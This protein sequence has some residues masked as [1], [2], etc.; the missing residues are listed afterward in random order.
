MNINLVAFGIA[1]DILGNSTQKF[2]LKKGNT[3]EE[4]KAELTSEF[5]K[6]EELAS[7]K[8]AVNETYQK[9]DFLLSE[10]DEVV[11]IP[12]VSGG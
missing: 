6:F 9:D 1:R 7:L 4:L 5:P 2:D 3:I 12:P 10:N 8:F 11:I